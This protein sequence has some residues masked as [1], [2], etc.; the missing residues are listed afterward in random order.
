MPFWKKKKVIKGSPSV[1]FCPKCLKSTLKSAMNVSGFISQ[2]TFL[3]TNCGYMGALYIEVDPNE[4]GENLIDLEKIKREFPN[5][6]ESD[7]ENT[8]ESLEKK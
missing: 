5:D 8:P 7:D 1:K 2:P 3:C 4:N 6:V